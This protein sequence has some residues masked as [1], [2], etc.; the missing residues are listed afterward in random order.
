MAGSEEVERLRDDIL[1]NP[2][3]RRCLS[4][5]KKDFVFDPERVMFAQLNRKELGTK[6][7]LLI[8]LSLIAGH[9]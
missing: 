9:S 7:S 4:S 3:V 5:K 6:A 2:I 1:F 8:G